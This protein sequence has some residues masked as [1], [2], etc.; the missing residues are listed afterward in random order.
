VENLDCALSK[1]KGT[2]LLSIHFGNWE[3][4][5]IG[6]ALAGYKI[7]F[8]VRAHKNKFTN[9]LF[10]E[11]RSAKKVKVIS[12]KQ[13]KQVIKALKGNEIVAILAD[14]ENKKGVS[15]DL[16]NQKV[17]LASGPFKLAY[18]M[19][20]LISPAFMIRDRK[21][22]KQKGVVEPPIEVNTYLPQ[23]EAVRGAAQKFARVMED[24]LRYYPDHWLLLKNKVIIQP[25]RHE[26]TKQT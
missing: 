17:I 18:Q 3:W 16:F 8:L 6:L 12:T 26:D 2:V 9:R 15:V 22:G 10:S 25:P 24:Y 21:T 20:A 11:I 5:G 1:R 4:G 19:K 13:L 7:N 23:K 14:E